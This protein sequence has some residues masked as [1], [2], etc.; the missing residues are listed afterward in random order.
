MPRGPTAEGWPPGA[1][2]AAGM[3]SLPKGHQGGTAQPPAPDCGI[4]KHKMNQNTTVSSPAADV[5]P[6]M[7]TYTL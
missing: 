6:L 1:L 3:S 7:S 4:C 2:S 5:K